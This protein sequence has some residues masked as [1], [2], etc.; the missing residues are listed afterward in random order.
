MTPEDEK[1]YREYYG[2]ET[3]TDEEL[4]RLAKEQIEQPD[5]LFLDDRLAEKVEAMIRVIKQE[6]TAGG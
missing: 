2:E 3:T 5:G 1:L 4:R 6:Q